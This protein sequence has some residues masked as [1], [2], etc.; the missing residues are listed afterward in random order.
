MPTKE[1]SGNL[2]NLAPATSTTQANTSKTTD[3]AKSQ[4]IN[5]SAKIITKKLTINEE[6]KCRA[7]ELYQAFTNLDVIEAFSKNTLKLYLNLFLLSIDIKM[8]RAFTHSSN[9]VYE[10]E[11]G[12]KFSLFDSN[13]SGSF[14]ELVNLVEFV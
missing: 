1:S 9:I 3:A 11:K 6:F 5:G 8:V 4:E 12:G 14:V 2:K 7:H 13:V 10:P